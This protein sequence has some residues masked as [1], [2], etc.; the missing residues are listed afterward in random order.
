MVGH[1]CRKQ[2]PS[3]SIFFPYGIAICSRYRNLREGY[4]IQVCACLRDLQKECGCAVATSDLKTCSAARFVGFFR[5]LVRS[6]SNNKNKVPKIRV[7]TTH[8]CPRVI[9]VADW[10]AFSLH[11]GFSWHS[12]NCHRC[13]LSIDCITPTGRREAPCWFSDKRGVGALWITLREALYWNSAAVLS[14]MW[15]YVDLQTPPPARTATVT[16]NIS[17]G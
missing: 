14:S 5:F 8:R 13:S 10:E 17:L 7:S 12:Q 9:I 4:K 2:T 15:A 3:V 16:D 1:G 6:Q 11:P